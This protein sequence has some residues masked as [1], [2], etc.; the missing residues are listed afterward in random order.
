VEI[1]PLTGA[2]WVKIAPLHSREFAAHPT[3][4]VFVKLDWRCY[5]TVNAWG[6]GTSLR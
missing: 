2:N 6:C 4:D 1:P 3:C 5:Y